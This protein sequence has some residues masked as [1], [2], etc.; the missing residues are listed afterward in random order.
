MLRIHLM[1]AR[2][3]PARL[4]R[5]AGYTFGRVGLLCLLSALVLL[6]SSY[7]PSV[8]LAQSASSDAL[9]PGDVIR[10]RIWRE[11]D[12]SGDFAVD[13]TGGVVLPRI[14][15]IKVTDDSAESLKARL[16]KAYSAFLNHSSIDVA[17]LRRLQVLGAV[18]NPGL[19]PVDATMTIADAL[20]LAGGTTPQGHPDRVELVRDGQRL[21]ARLSRN[22]Q[23]TASQIRSGD[24]IFVPERS[25]VSRN[26]GVVAA[27][28]TASVS[29]IVALLTLY[30]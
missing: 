25:W 14:G 21:E 18:R 16:V 27:G 12:M 5:A 28:I 13:E 1:I 23:L 29:I 11:P 6:A 17:L 9:R 2:T 7:S 19:Y 10:L 8:A 22:M 15:P 26:T 24:Q 4:N 3:T 30:Y 20:A